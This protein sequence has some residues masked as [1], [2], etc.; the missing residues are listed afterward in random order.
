MTL[1][2]LLEKETVKVISVGKM[3]VKDKAELKTLLADVDRDDDQFET[4]AIKFATS[5]LKKNGFIREKKSVEKSLSVDAII[6]ALEVAGTSMMELPSV[7]EFDIVMIAGT[8][9]VLK[10]GNGSDT[11]Y[12]PISKT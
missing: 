8:D 9:T 2:S 1:K 12:H 10:I 7:N 5:I 3:S 6:M 4:I 11:V